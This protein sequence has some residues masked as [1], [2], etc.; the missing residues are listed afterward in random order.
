MSD[1]PDRVPHLLL[2]QRPAYLGTMT[3]RVQ[4]LTAV[5][6]HKHLILQRLYRGAN[7]PEASYSTYAS[8]WPSSNDSSGVSATAALPYR[9]NTSF[10]LLTCTSLPRVFT[11]S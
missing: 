9:S 4:Q 2:Q 8:V 1:Q 10:L 3:A 6:L 7:V 11:T 5:C